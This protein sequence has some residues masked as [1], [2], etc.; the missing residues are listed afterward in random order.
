MEKENSTSDAD[1]TDLGMPLQFSQVAVEAA[2]SA[3]ELKDETRELD[4]NQ[5]TA[6]NVSAM[7][8]T[9]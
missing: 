3:Q 9:R 7:H 8:L 6:K 1:S 4:D 5:N 2:V